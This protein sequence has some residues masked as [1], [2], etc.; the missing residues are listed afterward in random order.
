MIVVTMTKE[1]V[2]RVPFN[3]MQFMLVP[4]LV[5]FILVLSMSLI[6]LVELKTL[7]EE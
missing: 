7:L 6:Y 5:S 4:T 3:L 1:V 2:K